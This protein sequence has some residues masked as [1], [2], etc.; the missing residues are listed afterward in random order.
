MATFATASQSRAPEGPAK[1]RGGKSSHK[2]PNR[3]TG[4]ARRA[5]P[6]SMCTDSEQFVADTLR[7][8]G[9]RAFYEPREFTLT[10]QGKGKSALRPDFYLPRHDV[11]LEISQGNVLNI[12]HKRAK[13]ANA[14]KNH[15]GIWIIL[16]GPD[17]LEELSSGNVTLD[18]IIR[19]GLNVREAFENT[20]RVA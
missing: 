13:I 6:P 19:E 7:S 2:P 16:I 1:V 15:P 18:E 8:S 12:N 5:A 10:L 11:Y 20:V 14:H 4:A 9:L 17:E 3:S